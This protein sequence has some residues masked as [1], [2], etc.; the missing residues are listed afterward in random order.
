M[1]VLDSHRF[2]ICLPRTVLPPKSISFFVMDAVSMFMQRLQRGLMGREDLQ[3][4]G[5][6]Y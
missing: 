5:F 6:I 4:L 2:Q 1:P 3:T